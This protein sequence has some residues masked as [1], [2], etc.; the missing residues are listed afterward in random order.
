MKTEH[1]IKAAATF[2]R[3]HLSR[4]I[5]NAASVEQLVTLKNPKASK[6]FE[7]AMDSHAVSARMEVA[8]AEGYAAALRWVLGDQS[9]KW[10]NDEN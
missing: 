8:R 3:G 9:P 10:W 6:W 5:T 1:E 2:Y 7:K 4:L